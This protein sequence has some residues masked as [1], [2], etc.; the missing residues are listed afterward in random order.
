MAPL[1]KVNPKLTL[2]EA[3]EVIDISKA[4]FYRIK[5]ELLTEEFN[6]KIMGKN[7]NIR[8]VLRLLRLK[9]LLN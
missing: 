2:E 3:K 1:F 6:E 8:L 4:S 5:A 7:L 9:L